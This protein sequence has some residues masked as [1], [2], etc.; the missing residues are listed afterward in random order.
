MFGYCFFIGTN[1]KT[2]RVGI[3][4]QELTFKQRFSDQS[5]AEFKELESS[6]L[7]AVSL[8]L[9]INV[10]FGTKCIQYVLK[11]LVYTLQSN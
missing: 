9:N 6:L 3:R 11:V 8:I 10:M 2:E 1:C 7:S 5:T 4:I